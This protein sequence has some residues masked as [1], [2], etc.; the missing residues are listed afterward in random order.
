MGSNILGK[1][2]SFKKIVMGPRINVNSQYKKDNCCLAART[3][4]RT[5][6]M[7]VH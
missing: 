7:W 3:Q 2:V 5:K 1:Q 4:L 6:A